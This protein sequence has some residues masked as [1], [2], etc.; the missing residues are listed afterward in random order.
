V[1]DEMYGL[2]KSEEKKNELFN[3]IKNLHGYSFC[4]SH[5]FSYAELIYKLALIKY[6]NPKEF[7]ISTLK[8]NETSYKKWVHYYEARLKDVD[9][10]NIISIEKSIYSANKA[11][12]I[13][14]LDNDAHFEKYGIWNISD[15]KFYPNCYGFLNKDNSNYYFKG[16]IAQTKVLNKT[17]ILFL[18]VGEGKYIEVVINNH[19][20]NKANFQK[21]IVKGYGKLSDEK[22][23]IVKCLK[24]SYL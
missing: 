15:G 20:F 19:R 3:K 16:I 9:F 10:K 12:D 7:W 24:Y 22:L 11:K 6:Y 5:A 14:K 1:I 21:K 2:C 4:K 17:I 23:Q 18:G 13:Y 8:H